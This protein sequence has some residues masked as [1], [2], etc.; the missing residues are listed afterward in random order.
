MQYKGKKLLI[1][2]PVPIY[3]PK[4][5]DPTM[6]TIVQMVTPGIISKGIPTGIPTPKARDPFKGRAKAKVMEREKEKERAKA[7]ASLFQEN[8]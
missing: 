1:H 5:M 4:G 3:R 8:A 7:K 6:A 2:H